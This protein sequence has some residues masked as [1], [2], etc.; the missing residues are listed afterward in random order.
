MPA[1]PGGPC[2]DCGDIMPLNLI[3]CQTCRAMLNSD[4]IHGPLKQPQFQPLPEIDTMQQVMPVGHYVG[5]PSCQKELRISG[6]YLG[7]NVQCKFCNHPFAF[8]Q[9]TP[10]LIW[11][12]IYTNCPHCE[13]ELR[14]ARKYVGNRVACN[15]CNGPVML[16][17][18]TNA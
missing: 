18:A 14:A 6:K 3:H 13:K 1:W 11:N 10:S 17:E 7:Q 2:P 16:M 15:F 9:A 5:C 12:A 8:S 4:F